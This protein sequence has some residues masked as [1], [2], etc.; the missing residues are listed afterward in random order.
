M[1][2][3]YV[4]SRLRGRARD[5][6]FWNSFASYSREERH[7]MEKGDPLLDDDFKEWDDLR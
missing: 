6:N 1:I 2:L 4:L 5:K 3:I 7:N